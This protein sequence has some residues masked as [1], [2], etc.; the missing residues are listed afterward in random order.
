MLSHSACKFFSLSVAF[1][2]KPKEAVRP[3]QCEVVAPTIACE[4]YKSEFPTETQLRQLPRRKTCRGNMNLATNPCEVCGRELSTY[5]YLRLQQTRA[6]PKES[7]AK[8]MQLVQESTRQFWTADEEHALAPIE[9]DMGT[10][11]RHHKK[12]RQTATYKEIIA[13]ELPFKRK[14]KKSAHDNSALI[15]AITSLNLD[16]H[17]DA[18]AWPDR[19]EPLDSKQGSQMDTPENLFIRAF[20]EIFARR[21]EVLRLNTCQRGFSK[22]DG[23]FANVFSF[24]ENVNTMKQ[25][26]KPVCAITTDIAKAF[27]TVSHKCVT[28]ALG[29]LVKQGGSI[30][31]ILFNPALDELI[32]RLQS[33]NG[34]EVNNTQIRCLAYADDLMLL[35]KTRE[36]GER[37]VEAVR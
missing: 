35:A 15:T 12:R 19:T 24:N 29:M 4:T 27:D 16:M 21:L 32:C 30:S 34:I 37:M 17:D 5:A 1:R 7:N 13:K 6:H 2:A 36:N 28:R 9:L 33:L 22:L 25:Q 3:A 14:K 8:E 31:P 23:C 18:R 10:A 20:Q 11:T 26:E